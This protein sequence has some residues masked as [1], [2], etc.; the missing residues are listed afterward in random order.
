MSYHDDL[1]AL[2]RGLLS[3]RDGKVD[4]ARQR[5]AVSTAY[6]ALFHLLIDEASS[7]IATDGKVRSRVK[8]AF[9]H[10]T[11]KEASSSFEGGT[12]PEHIRSLPG[13]ELV[14][15]DLRRVASLFRE[16]QEGRHKADYDLAETF[17]PTDAMDLVDKAEEAFL[18]WREIRKTDSACLFLYTLIF[19]RMWNPERRRRYVD[20]GRPGPPSPPGSKYPIK[21]APPED[22][23]ARSG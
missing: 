17:T 3:G 1:L 21:Y 8:R 14:P 23:T 13:G 10:S 5:R 16:L 15:G 11:M 4:E 9:D 12:L 6:Y 20:S 2:A 22:Y 7:R 19:G 18:R